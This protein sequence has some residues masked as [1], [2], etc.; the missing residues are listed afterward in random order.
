MTKKRIEALRGKLFE[1]S[2]DAYLVTSYENYRYFSGFSGSNCTLI[3]TKAEAFA[4]TDG[5][6]TVQIKTQTRGFDITIAERTMAEHIA[7]IL[8]KTGAHSVGYETH[9]ITDFSLRTIKEN[10]PFC[11]FV[12]CPDFG[13]EIR[14]VKD[15]S[16]IASIKAAA[17][18]ADRA[19][20]KLSKSLSRGMT[21]REAAAYLDYQML[22]GKSEGAAFDTIAASGLRGSMP[23]AQA[24]N[25]EI[26]ENCLMTFDFGATVSGYKSDITRTVHIGNP[27][28]ELLSLFD[29]VLNVQQKCVRKV[30]TG[31]SAKELDLFA[32]ELFAKDGLDK[33]FTHSLGHGVGL[34]VHEA[35]TLSRRSDTVLSE[36]M[37]IT[38]EPGLY[39]EGLGGVRIEDSVVVTSGGCDVLT[40]SPH[41]INISL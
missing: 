39:V 7:E 8:K 41:R 6:Y 27:G 1:K 15:E 32:R 18:I 16:E 29:A 38:I 3:I 13:E 2:L 26:S 14:M 35:P 19:F 22:L 20:E 24:T 9:K 17:D 21:E 31:I 34:A 30:A 10:S 11:E 4:I 33:Y 5:R 25:E 40:R 23:H 36:G 12:P 28:K 37:V